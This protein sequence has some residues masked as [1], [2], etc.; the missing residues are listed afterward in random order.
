MKSFMNAESISKLGLNHP[1]IIPSSKTNGTGLCNASV[2]NYNGNLLVNIRLLNYTLYHSI[3]AKYWQDE[4]GKFPSRWGPLTYVHPEDDARLVTDNYFGIW[5]KNNTN[6]EKI[7]MNLDDD[8]IWAFAGLEDC[9]L[10]HWD[11]KI[12]ITGV[13]RDTTENGQGRMELSEIVDVHNSPKEV[14]R[15]RIEHPT[16]PTRYCEKNWMP[17]SGLPFHYI[18]DANP[19]RLVKADPVTGDCELVYVGEEVPIPTNM[20]GSS[21]V[22]S[23]KGG[24]ITVVHDTNWWRFENRCAENK[25]A[26]YSHRFVIWDSQ[27]NIER[28]SKQFSFMDGQ[29]EFSCGMDI[30][31]ESFYITFGFEDN[32]AH[33]LEIKCDVIDEWIENN[34]EFSR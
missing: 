17:V 12:Y 16:D 10:V 26:I 25:D 33:M 8:S 27:W 21:Q 7:N 1:L 34:L 3:G 28:V 19:T 24:Y 2:L 23:Y 15:V 18:M 22:I 14:S 31:D 29:I 20:R 30:L 9:R 4:G 6:F 32:S 5:N 13:R 11:E